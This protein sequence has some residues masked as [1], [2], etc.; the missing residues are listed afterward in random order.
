MNRVPVKGVEYTPQ[1]LRRTDDL[2][3]RT[4]DE[5]VPE[6]IIG[7][8]SWNRVQRVEDAMKRAIVAG[9]AQERSE[10]QGRVD[11]LE[12][13]TFCTFRLLE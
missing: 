12:C 5:K 9:N 13:I 11:E 7:R 4:L 1:C 8:A 10:V 3:L 2:L 6:Y